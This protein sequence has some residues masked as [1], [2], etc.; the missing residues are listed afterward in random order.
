MCQ[1]LAPTR[2]KTASGQHG[3]NGA[4]LHAGQNANTCQN[5]QHGPTQD[6]VAE[7]AKLAVSPKIHPYNQLAHGNANHPHSRIRAAAA[8]QPEKNMH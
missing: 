2:A 5:S 3:Q 1:K 6:N 7:H 8:P 4:R